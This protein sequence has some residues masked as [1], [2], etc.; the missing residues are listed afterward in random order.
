[1]Q[2]SPD[3]A[4]RL[5]TTV[6]ALI[7]LRRARH[8]GK[9][10]SGLQLARVKAQLLEDFLQPRG[11]DRPRLHLPLLETLPGHALVVV[12]NLHALDGLRRMTGP[13]T[14]H[15]TA[16]PFLVQNVPEGLGLA[17]KIADGTNSPRLRIGFGEAVNA[18]LERP[19]P[20]CNRGPQHGR[21]DGVQG[22]QVA[23]YPRI[24]EL[25]YR[26]HLALI[27]QAMNHL[28]VRGIPADEENFSF[29]ESGVGN[30][31]APSVSY[32]RALHNNAGQ[33]GPARGPSQPGR[34]DIFR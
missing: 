10:V 14:H 23:A 3:L 18:A 15:R 17:R 28:P 21:Q 32:C 30:R 27:H 13:P 16:L 1:M 19:L 4:D 34:C 9:D 31:P 20:G 5:Q 12:G 24:D 7:D 26:G 29:L 11:V 33:E 2:S 6:A 8:E 22:G 25:L